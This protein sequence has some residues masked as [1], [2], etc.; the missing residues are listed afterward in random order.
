AGGLNPRRER[1]QRNRTECGMRSIPMRTTFEQNGGTALYSR[2]KLYQFAGFADRFSTSGFPSLTAR[3]L[4][5]TEANLFPGQA[6]NPDVQ[7]CPNEKPGGK[8][9]RTTRTCPRSSR[10]PAA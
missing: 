4:D 5:D 9:W 6:E 1:Q 10:S 7:R 8:N 2:T 3:P